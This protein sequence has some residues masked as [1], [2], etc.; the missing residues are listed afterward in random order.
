MNWLIFVGVTLLTDSF[1]IFLDNYI[2]DFYF[3]GKGAASQ[4]IFHG[5]LQILVA[6]V[7]LPFAGIDFATVQPLT[8][9]LFV[10]SGVLA[11][12]AGI[13]YYKALELDDSTN[14]GI[15]MQL[16]PVLYL[17]LGWLF[18]GETISPIQLVAFIVILAAPVLILRTTQKRSRKVK[19][20]ALMYAFLYVFILVVGN[21][22]FLKE[23][24]EALGF[25]GEIVLFFL[26]KGFSNVVIVGANKTWRQRFK[27]VMRRNPKKLPR[28]L[29]ANT[30][31]SMISDASYRLSLAIAPSV[32]LA[33]AAS[34]AVEPI[35]IF[36]MGII[37][38]LI[39]P[40]F[41]REKLGRK[42]VLVH[43]GATILVVIGVVLIQI[44]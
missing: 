40:K 29:V 14:L 10:L 39:R 42:P 6:F 20:K 43:L 44:N 3:K 17:I 9:G 27:Y 12:V 31:L 4:K 33:S 21:M 41:G 35:V 1:R 5:A 18:L 16:T 24:T 7:I 34:D 26:G 22:I 23:E 19:V 32:A 37:L 25:G 38:T 8:V 30:A 13:P 28:L 15:F 2:S 11:T 36:F